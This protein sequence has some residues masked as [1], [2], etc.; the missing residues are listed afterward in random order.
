MYLAFGS[1]VRTQC[2]PERSVVFA[3]VIAGTARN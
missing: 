1:F 3:T 2:S